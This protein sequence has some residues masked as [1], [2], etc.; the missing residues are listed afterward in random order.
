MAAGA[1]AASIWVR[2][3]P[4]IPPVRTATLGSTPARGE[5][6]KLEG[7]IT[8][9][10]TVGVVCMIPD[11]T[12]NTG[13]VDGIVARTIDI[14]PEQQHIVNQCGTSTEEVTEL[15]RVTYHIANT[16]NK[17]P[18]GAEEI[19]EATCKALSRKEGSIMCGSHS[20]GPVCVG[21]ENDNIYCYGSDSDC[22]WNS[23]AGDCSPTDADCQQ[24]NSD[25][26]KYTDSV[27]CNDLYAGVTAWYADACNFINDKK[28]VA[29]VS[30]HTSNPYATETD[31]NK[32]KVAIIT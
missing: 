19:D 32:Q 4:R 28:I 16:G 5:V 14:Q 7:E 9:D 24:Y 3:I 29:F 23:G 6:S 31:A 20:D 26:L 11:D 12:I 18:D 22:L 10:G 13:T 8:G 25:S 27:S 1:R 15:E 21:V 17:C 30:K 2:G